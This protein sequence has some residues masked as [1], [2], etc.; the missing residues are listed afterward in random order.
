MIEIRISATFEYYHF[1]TWSISGQVS[2]QINHC[3]IEVGRYRKRLQ[4]TFAQWHFSTRQ[5]VKNIVSVAAHNFT[6]ERVRMTNKPNLVSKLFA[7]VFL[8]K[9][10]KPSNQSRIKMKFRFV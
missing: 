8:V 6:E 4:L 5:H 1:A 3:E 7:E 2:D 10:W 9:L